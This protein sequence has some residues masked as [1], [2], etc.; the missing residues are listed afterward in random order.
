MTG[1]KSTNFLTEILKTLSEVELLGVNT[2]I[3][4]L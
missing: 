4:L 2:D 3:V 1:I